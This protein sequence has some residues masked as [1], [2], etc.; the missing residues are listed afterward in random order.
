MTMTNSENKKRIKLKVL[1]VLEQYGNIK[2]PV[3]IKNIVRFLGYRL[4]PYS[5]FCADHSLTYT[6]TVNYFESDDACA[7]Y[8]ANTNCYVLYFNDMDELKCTSNRVRW[9]I[10]HELGHIVLGHHKEKKT[11]L[12]RNS[13]SSK[14][15]KH[16]EKEADWFASYI[17]APYIILHYQQIKE[18]K[19]IARLCRISVSASKYRFA[20]Y[21]LWVKRIQSVPS[22]YQIEEYDKRVL[23]LYNT[24]NSNQDKIV[25]LRCRNI[26]G[27]NDVKYCCIC[28]ARRGI[29]KKENKK[30]VYKGIELDNNKRVKICPLCNNEELSA[31]DTFCKICGTALY[32]ECIQYSDL[33]FSDVCH[34]GWPLDGNAR[35]CPF[36]GQPS[37]FF[38]NGFLQNWDHTLP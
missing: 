30:M 5:T 1:S 7:E 29:Y 17:L 13:L 14:E 38:Q 27:Y 10:A 23:E 4:V 33:P 24:S 2:L 34:K 22:K 3:P 37:T 21:C 36:C 11:R 28:G 18:P 8:E 15:Y 20:D 6:E 35:Y 32:N 26:T 31:E 9:S 19:D 25:C 12:F 16:L